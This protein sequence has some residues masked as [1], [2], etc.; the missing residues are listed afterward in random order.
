[1]L[2]SDYED[3]EGSGKEEPVSTGSDEDSL[4]R[5]SVVRRNSAHQHSP[6]TGNWNKFDGNGD[7]NEPL[8]LKVTIP[9][10][11][12][13]GVL[14]SN[15]VGVSDS[16]DSA[17]YNETKLVCHSTG[18]FYGRKTGRCFYKD[19][20]GSDDDSCY[21]NSRRKATKKVKYTVFSDSEGEHEV[22][23][24]ESKSNRRNVV[25]V[26]YNSDSDFVVS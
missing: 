7:K 17:S 24:A 19:N 21:G 18:N 3:D 2:C 5:Q 13:S 6:Q 22:G 12:S 9:K 14:P 25:N 20:S 23:V 10:E 11:Y 26:G 8:S 16:D 15:Q 1:M 4:P